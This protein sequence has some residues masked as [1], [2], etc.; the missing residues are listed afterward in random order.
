MAC[1]FVD[2]HEG[3]MD[4]IRSRAEGLTEDEKPRTFI[5][6][7][8]KD[9]YFTC[10]DGTKGD[11]ICTMAG[12]VN[13]AHD[14]GS[15]YFDVEPEWVME[16]NPDIVI[17]P[18]FGSDWGYAA[19]EAQKQEWEAEM[20]SVRVDTMSRPGWTEM[21]ED[22][23]IVSGD[24]AQS[25]LQGFVYATYMAKWFHPDMFED[26]SPVVI[27]QEY[28]DRFLRIDYDVGEHGAFVY[29]PLE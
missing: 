10:G 26:I 11:E 27:H 15:Y 17:R 4:T 25:G 12:G 2:F 22:I 13:I 9:G 28:I 16:Q 21:T 18:T 5:E 8:Y 23:Y 19:D 6:Y 7:V 24:I 1:E 29:P 3:Y 20:E 14:T